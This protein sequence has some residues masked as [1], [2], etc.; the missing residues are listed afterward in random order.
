MKRLKR[1]AALAIA[2]ALPLAI[3]IPASAGN[4]NTL[5]IGVGHA[6][7]ANQNP[8][9]GRVWSYTD[10][11]SRTVTV[12]PGD[13]LDFRTAPGEF[14]V[15][16]L[17]TDEA[18]VRAANRIF[19]PDS[20]DANA[21]GS[22]KPKITLGPGGPIVFSS[23]TCGV[24]GQ[25]PCVFTGSTLN[26]GAIA[27]FGPTGPM[28]VDW[29]VKIHAPF[30]TYAYFC[31]IH[32]AM[33]GTLVVAEGSQ[34]SSQAEI[35]AA[36]AAQF[37]S[38]HNQALAAET[39]AN[40]VTF[41]GGAPGTRTYEAHVGLSAA[42]N[43]VALLEMVPAVLNL[44]R[45]DKVHYTWSF[46]EIH[47]ASFPANNDNVL[48]EPTGWDCGATYVPSPPG[49]PQPPPSCVEMEP[50]PELLLDPGNA[51]PGHLNNPNAL[52]DSGV[53]VGSG[54]NLNPSA[55][56]WSVVADTGGRYAYQCTIHDWMQG[57]VNVS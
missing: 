33:S 23:P 16:A 15:I 56:D 31:H 48:V 38:D 18:A 28:A 39:A 36:S 29:T 13:S 1:L 2:T 45:G 34:A 10:F 14:H 40:V 44:A 54:Y 57:I 50:G 19:A 42:D 3:A 4:G 53:L 32:P 24:S 49:P 37:A 30:G 43:H 35:D 7:P 22:G 25:K 8:Q 47:T 52:V 20:D 11:F 51:R 26:A 9:T 27:G 46:Q 6:D 12:H 5:V 41:T 21:A 17:T 55:Q